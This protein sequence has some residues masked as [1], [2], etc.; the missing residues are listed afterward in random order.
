MGPKDKQMDKKMT[1]HKQVTKNWKEAQGLYEWSL[2]K[3]F[4]LIFRG[5]LQPNQAPFIMQMS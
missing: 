4:V 3:V 5:F 2:C 1:A